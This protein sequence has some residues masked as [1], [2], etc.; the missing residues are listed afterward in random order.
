[1]HQMSLAYLEQ[2]CWMVWLQRGALQL[3]LNGRA[4]SFSNVNVQEGRLQ[5]CMDGDAAG[6]RARGAGASREHLHTQSHSR[7]R[8]AQKHH[9]TVWADRSRGGD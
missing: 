1:M 9:V 4:R 3:R 8:V 6:N 2:L 5:I 7:G